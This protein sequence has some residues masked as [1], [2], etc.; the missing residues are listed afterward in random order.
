[1][2]KKIKHIIL[3]TIMTSVFSNVLADKYSDSLLSV[4]DTAKGL[5]KANAFVEMAEHYFYNF[6][7]LKTVELDS[8]L[9]YFVQA[10][11]ITAS[12][13]DVPQT[14]EILSKLSLIYYS[15][16]EY[17]NS[18]YI[19]LFLLKIYKANGNREKE[20]AHLNRIALAYRFIGER[21]KA[22]YYSYQCEKI[23]LK[24][25]LYTSLANVKIVMAEM[26]MDS[27]EYS[28]AYEK[29]KEAIYYSKIQ[30]KI[31]GYPF[32]KLLT[33]NRGELP[34]KRIWSTAMTY[35][36]TGHC[37]SQNK[38]YSTALAYLD[39]AEIIASG[40][41]QGPYIFQFIMDTRKEIWK[42]LNNVDSTL[43]YTELYI[44]YKDSVASSAN[45]FNQSIL[46][47]IKLSR[48]KKLKLLQQENEIKELKIQRIN[49]IIFGVILLFVIFIGMSYLLVRQ[50]RIKRMKDKVQLEQRALQLQMNPHF[51]S[52]ALVAI[53][54]FIF[55]GEKF[56]AGKFLSDFSELM[57]LILRNSRES[58][59]SLDKEISLLEHYLELQQLRYSDKFEW[60]IAID[61]SVLP[62]H[63]FIPPMLT[64]P[65][66]ENAV[67]HGVVPKQ[68]AGKINITFRTEGD[69]LVYEVK[70]NGVGRKVSASLKKNESRVSL[71]TE[72]TIERLK[73]ITKKKESE[74]FQYTDVLERKNI[75]SGTI[76]TMKIP[77]KFLKYD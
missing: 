35:V 4:A 70:D 75:P 62:E 45:D 34:Q 43:K 25:H 72:I 5:V 7:G 40:G 32:K 8:T 59:I 14:L 58:H 68:G 37:L 11:G 60:F 16:K 47:V 63:I 41:A 26:D 55:T 22:F 42:K 77:F 67:E 20:A 23:C 17:S 29:L 53:Q 39:T 30:L 2:I 19:D 24:Y 52:N 76:V 31:E 57:R 71:S 13:N 10:L 64:Q 6:Y 54:S 1:M 69:F 61:S 51:I 28:K 44:I 12:N 48:E 3:I 9:K 21:E 73:L 65:F 38:A 74:I 33:G 66:V 49:V 18:L 36:A 56:Q 50:Q 27:G 46:N 15:V